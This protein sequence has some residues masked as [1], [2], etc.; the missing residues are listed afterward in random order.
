MFIHN[1][2]HWVI[3]KNTIPWNIVHYSHFYT[4]LVFAEYFRYFTPKKRS[5]ALMGAHGGFILCIVSVLTKAAGFQRWIRFQQ[6]HSANKTLRPKSI[7][8]NG[9][10]RG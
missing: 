7:S 1:G 2:K 9:K 5:A 3:K 4:L 10:K 6:V 8:P